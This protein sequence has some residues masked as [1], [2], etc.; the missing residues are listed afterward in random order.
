MMLSKFISRFLSRPT[1]YH[2]YSLLQLVIGQAPDISHLRIYY[3]AVCIPISLPQRTR[4]AL[5]EDWN[6]C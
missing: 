1:A 2:I 3:C 5:K 4:M 6:L